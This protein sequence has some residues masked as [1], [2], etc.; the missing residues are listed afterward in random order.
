MTYERVALKY[1]ECTSGENLG[2][3]SSIHI[4]ILRLFVVG[5][6]RLAMG[7]VG[8]AFK[9]CHVLAEFEIACGSNFSDLL[10]LVGTT[11]AVWIVQTVAVTVAVPTGRYRPLIISID[12][13]D[14][15][16]PNTEIE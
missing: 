12:Q 15:H 9:V 10:G 2:N 4:T 13:P 16:S 1:W 6:P 8:E 11:L 14:V 7:D 5:M 3:R